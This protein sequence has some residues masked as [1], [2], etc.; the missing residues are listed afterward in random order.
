MGYFENGELIPFRHCIWHYFKI[1][2][3]SKLTVNYEI[4]GGKSWWIRTPLFCIGH[5]KNSWLYDRVNLYTG[6]Q[7]SWIPTRWSF[8]FRKGEILYKRSWD[9][10]RMTIDLV[11][12]WVG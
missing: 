1:G 4:N 8:R 5:Y 7:I 12:T 3:S 10:L 6:W 9:N 2:R 11:N